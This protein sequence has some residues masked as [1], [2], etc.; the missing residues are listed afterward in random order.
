MARKYKSIL[1]LI[2]YIVIIFLSD[3]LKTHIEKKTRINMNKNTYYKLY[4]KV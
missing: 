2:T 1:E 3:A 4:L